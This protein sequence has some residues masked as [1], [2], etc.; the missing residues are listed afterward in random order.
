MPRNPDDPSPLGWLAYRFFH[1]PRT[2]WRKRQ[3]DFLLYLLVGRRVCSGPFAGLRYVG[4]SPNEHIGDAL[5][6]TLEKEIHPFVQRLLREE[7]DVFVNIGAAEGYYAIGF[8]VFGRVPRVIA[9][10]GDRFGRVLTRFMARRNGVAEKLE[11][12][13]Y[14]EAADL[15]DT[16]APFRRPALLVDIEGFEAKVLDPAINPHLARATMIVE[17]HEMQLPMADLLRPRFAAT[18]T[19]EEVWGQP[20][21][22]ADLPAHMG[23]ARLWFS[24]E[25]LVKCMDERR[26]QAMRWWLLTPRTAPTTAPAS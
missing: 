24:R 3:P 23:A 10:E 12:R 19:I 15:V 9:Y 7:F 16:L 22:A 14:C 26:G 13:G 5:L 20:R 25:R 2:A 11:M 18:H 21:T 1:A 8:A 17:L 6:G 4:S